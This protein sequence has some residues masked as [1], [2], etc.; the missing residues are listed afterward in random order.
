MATTT[1][2]TIIARPDHAIS[3]ADV[4]ENALKVLYRLRKAGYAAFLVGGCV[5]DQLLGREP[6]DFDVATDA[7]PEQVRELFRNCRLVGRRFRLAHV[8]YRDEIIEVATFRGSGNTDG[9]EQITDD[10]VYGTIEEDAL[11]RDFTINALYYNIDDFSVV[12]YTGAM[13]DLEAGMLRMIGDPAQRYREDPVR[14]LR[15]VRF[16]V[17]LGFRIHPDSEAPIFELAH[18][19]AD[20]PA[21][22]LYEEVLKL[23]QG[24]AALQTF[25]QLRHYGLFAHLFPMTEACLAVEEEGFPLTLVARALANT[26]RRV[27]EGKPITPAF[28]FAA[29]LWEPVRE[30]AASLRASGMHEMEALRS[31]GEAVVSEQVQH[32][33]VPRRFSV[34]SRE[35]WA[36]QPRL[37]SRRRVR[38]LFEHP[39]FRAAYDFL[40]LRAEAGDAG[41]AGAD[42]ADWWTRFQEK[43]GDLEV[44]A[45]D[46]APRRRRRRRGGRSR[47]KSGGG[48]KT[49]S[50]NTD[51]NSN[52]NS[53]TNPGNETP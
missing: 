21:A 42:A 47:S 50:S 34:Q 1:Q 52:G 32:V 24:G 4:S 14:M 49:G 26:D 39:R 25:E 37:V 48:N 9:G 30:H 11:R 41:D 17:K 22:R 3:R 20:I 46:A 35:I 36:M 2:P 23:F 53:N 7:L 40:V 19:L 43:G 31:A 13:A 51:S 8:R 12:D 33:A 44:P 10:N 38:A 6:K 45:D 16:A 29:L 15:A 28:L 27:A 18:L 5:R